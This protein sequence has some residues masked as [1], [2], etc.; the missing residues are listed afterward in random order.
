[1]RSQPH[2]PIAFQWSP[3]P[4]AAPAAGT[5]SQ[6]SGLPPYRAD[7]YELVPRPSTEPSFPTCSWTITILP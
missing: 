4:A 2:A 7:P 6:P 3:A 1:M 5:A